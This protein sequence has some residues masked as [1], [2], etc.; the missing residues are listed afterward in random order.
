[1]SARARVRSSPTLAVGVAAARARSGGRVEQ[2]GLEPKWLHLTMMMT[3]VVMMV[4][5]VMMMT[6]VMVII[7]MMMVVVAIVMVTNDWCAPLEH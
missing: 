7:V 4:V 3:V 1:M 5:I 6:M 2:P